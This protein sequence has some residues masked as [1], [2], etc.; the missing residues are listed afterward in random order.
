MSSHRKIAFFDFDGT[1]T[2]AD[3]MLELIKF[4]FG[5]LKFYAG[6][7]MISPTLIGFKAGL[8]SA[9]S[10]KEK[11]LSYFFKGLDVQEFD[12]LCAYFSKKKLPQLIRKEATGRITQLVSEITPVIVVTASAS[13]WVKFWCAENGLPL[14]ATKLKV[15]N[16]KLTGELDGPNC[17]GEE[18]VNRIRAAYS[19]E[20]FE[21]IQC[22]GDSPGDKAML[23]IATDPYY[24]RFK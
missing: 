1:I 10:A 22:Y 11:L 5:K 2:T 16:G 15:I 7:M 4:R 8:V 17:N 12:E 20:D 18:K 9:K 24:R 3:T 21:E 19:L 14:L 6:M 13:N 23:S